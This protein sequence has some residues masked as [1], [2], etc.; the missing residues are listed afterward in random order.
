MYM[1]AYNVHIKFQKRGSS[2]PSSFPPNQLD[3]QTL[4]YSGPLHIEVSVFPVG[5]LIARNFRRG[6]HGCLMC[7]Q[8]MD[9]ISQ[10]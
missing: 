2:V 7:E 3:Y 6:L 4:E 1:S 10:T 8:S 5:R 9:Y